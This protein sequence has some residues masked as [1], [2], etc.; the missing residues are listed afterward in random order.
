MHDLWAD[1]ESEQP[2]VSPQGPALPRRL[3]E[4]ALLTSLRTWLVSAY[5]ASYYRALSA[6]PLY[7]R[8]YW[9][10]ALGVAGRMKNDEAG[11]QSGVVE[12]PISDG[13]ASGKKRRRQEA[14]PP[15]PPVL[16]P[17]ATL[18]QALREEGRTL[19]LSGIALEAGSSRRKDTRAPREGGLSIPKEGGLV[20]ASWL[21]AGP[22]VLQTLDQSPAIFLLTPFGQTLF[23]G[24][25]LEPLCQ[26]TPPTELCLL[27]PHKQVEARLLASRRDPALAATLVSLLRSDRWKAL[28]PA[29][30]K[31]APQGAIESNVEL[32]QAALQRHFLSVQRIG[33]PLLQRPTVIEQAP[34]TLLFATR[35]QDSLLSMNDA[36]CLHRRELEEQ[37]HQGVLGAEWFATQLC[38]RRE[39]EQAR[40]AAR[41]LQ[42]GRTRRARRWPELRQQL[43]MAHFGRF[44]VEDYDA[45]LRDLLRSGEVICHWLRPLNPDVEEEERIPGNEDTLTWRQ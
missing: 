20:P 1:L 18:G 38:E 30:E 9:I 37:S 23:S 17:V 8:C 39:E 14:P 10:D 26:R 29:N 45:I 7:R 15:L 27:I 33:I 42:Q 34:Y 2:S 19:A 35:R 12:S 41:V 4:Q 11:G 21:E 40:L 6:N 5:M 31:T 25:D 36:V 32:L 44:T 43:L 16:Q 3:T 13:K 24:D 22:L 28:V